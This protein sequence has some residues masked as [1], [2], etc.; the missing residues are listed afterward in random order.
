M[1]SQADKI[2]VTLENAVDG[3]MEQVATDAFNELV[4]STPAV[5][6]PVAGGLEDE[7]GGNQHER[8]EAAQRQIPQAAHSQNCATDEGRR[9]YDLYQQRRSVHPGS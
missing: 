2:R 5:F 6:G 7:A 9:Q 8:S 1:P 3:L 4:A